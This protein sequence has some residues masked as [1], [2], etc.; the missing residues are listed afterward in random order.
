M[1]A[2]TGKRKPASITAAW[3]RFPTC[4]VPVSNFFNILGI[5]P[6]FSLPPLHHF[7][8]Q[9]NTFTPH[10]AET[11]PILAINSTMLE[12]GFKRQFPVRYRQLGR[13]S[14]SMFSTL[15]A[16]FRIFPPHR[17]ISFHHNSTLSHTFQAQDWPRAN[18]T[19]EIRN[20]LFSR[21]AKI[22]PCPRP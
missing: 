13:P 8:S 5:V 11:S 1:Q 4:P 3:G 22:P 15:W 10:R 6:H 9:F 19:S 18:P 16:L 17:F 21:S 20:P 7:S 14:F 2:K 12:I